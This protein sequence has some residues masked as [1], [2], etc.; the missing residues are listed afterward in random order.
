MCDSSLAVGSRASRPMAIRRRVAWPT[1]ITVFT[2]VAGKL[3]QILGKG[4]RLVVQPGC[5][6]PQVF[7][8]GLGLAGQHRRSGVAAVAHHLRGDSLADLAFGQRIQREGEVGVG[9]NV[10]ETRSD[11]L[12]RGIDLP[13]RL[14]V[15][16]VSHGSDAPIF[17]SN[18]RPPR[19]CP[20]P[21]N[22]LSTTDQ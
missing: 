15:F 20:V 4:A 5:P 8:K 12:S 2:E 1:C 16:A 3:V 10:D 9:V 17:N 22:H 19:R 13:L 21:V 14:P 18:V 7:L 6:C 11:D